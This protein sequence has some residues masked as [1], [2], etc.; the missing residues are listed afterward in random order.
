MVVSV[1]GH[2]MQPVLDIGCS[3]SVIPY[4]DSVQ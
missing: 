3:L 2:R 4:D 1:V